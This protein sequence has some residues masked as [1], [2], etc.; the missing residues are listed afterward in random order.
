MK[1][2]KKDIQTKI[3]YS[4]YDFLFQFPTLLCIHKQGFIF[5]YKQFLFNFDIVIPHPYKNAL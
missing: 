1:N 2:R 5:R 3:I 4:M